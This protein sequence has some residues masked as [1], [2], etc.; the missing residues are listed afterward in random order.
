MFGSN[1][2]SVVIACIGF[3]NAGKTSIFNKLTGSHYS[4]VNYPGSTVQYNLCTTT[5][6][7][8]RIHWI[9]TPGIVTFSPHSDD[10]R[11]T[12][13]VLTRLDSIV[14]DA[15]TT[16]N[17]LV[18]VADAFQ[19]ERHLMGLRVL[20]TQGYP[21][22]LIITRSDLIK[23]YGG[24]IDIRRLEHEIG[25]PVY[26]V[27]SHTGAGLPS[28]DTVVS[29]VPPSADRC[30]I[31]DS[32][33]LWKE[34]SDWAISVTRTTWVPP[35]S[36]HS[37]DRWALHPRWG[38]VVFILIMA[39][40]FFVIFSGASPAMDAIDAAWSLIT[41]MLHTWLPSGRWT[42]LVVDGVIANIGAVVVF[43]PQIFLLF[44]ATGI[45]ESSGY[46]ARAAVIV[47]RPLSKLGLSGRSF[48]PLLSGSACAIPAILA[49]RTL[50]HKTQR[51]ITL[52][53]IPL[54]PC[55]ARIPVYGLLLVMLFHGDPIKSAVGMV[56]IYAV[57]I[58]V[59]VLIG[60]IVS[61][62]SRS[63]ADS[64]YIELPR[65][66]MPHWPTILRNAS[67]H[68][69]QFIKKAGPAILV[70]SLAVWGLSQ[71][72]SVESSWLVRLGQW[73]AP[74][75]APMGWDWRIG[76]AILASFAAREVF[77]SVLAAMM[78]LHAD[79]VPA[80]LIATH[81]PALTTPSI[82]ALVVFFMIS[83]QCGTTIA[84]IRKETH[85]WTIPI[86]MT[87]A[88]VVLAYLAALVVAKSGALFGCLTTG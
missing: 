29:H 50:P 34:A 27:N 74:L 59:A 21:V 26:F 7:G 52:W 1:S 3:P 76:V 81:L 45:L 46:L 4:A 47:D 72:P 75:F 31:P 54:M 6:N 5:V 25:I 16:P 69:F 19:L 38:G 37:L 85:S 28:I 36:R 42:T 84:L 73:L 24:S 30:L 15:T 88:Y 49:T 65:Y 78:A 14:P 70:V 57:S 43:T 58:G 44:L 12:H 71:F 67:R 40:F 32:A 53:M 80:Q 2:P 23:K 48:V 20:Q 79:G 11:V 18:Y 64:F 77:V 63:A 51:L 35:I 41:Q 8:S 39:L 17:L 13:T 68:T 66:Q 55:S 61:L 86:A 83:M 33:Q 62:Y 10:E 22:V 60:K 9:D 56:G 82:L 87:V